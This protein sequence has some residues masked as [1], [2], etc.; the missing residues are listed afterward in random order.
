MER[1]TRSG[2]AAGDAGREAGARPSACWLCFC[3]AIMVACAAW[4][5]GR[6]PLIEPDEG[7][8]AEVAREMAVS[9]DFVL[10]HLDGLPY[11]DKPILFFAA[12]AAS[13][14]L[15][16]P[17][18]A[19]ARLPSFLFT[20][21]TLALTAWFG[22]CLLGR[23][24]GWVAA[25][26]TGAAPLT[27]VYARAVIFDAMLTFFV[28]LALVS[29]Y[30]AV[31]LQ[32]AAASEGGG[33]ERTRRAARWTALAWAAMGLGVLT[34]GPVALAVPLLVAVPYA[35]WR[36][37]W[38]ALWSPTAVALFAA[39]VL[40]W[41][42]AVTRRVPEFPRYVLFTET[43]GRLTSD[44][45]HRNEPWWY[46][47]FFITVGALPWSLVAATGVRRAGI[48]RPEGSAPDRRSVFILLWLLVPLIFFSLSHSKRPQY[49]LPLMPAVGLLVARLWS[50]R[51]GRLPGVRGAGAGLAALGLFLIVGHELVPSIRRVEPAV[52]DLIPRA[53]LVEG[54]LML[55]AGVA[56]WLVA[57]KR[58]VAL[59]ALSLPIAA[60]P[61][62]AHR[63]IVEISH[64]YSSAGIAAALRPVLTPQT[65]VIGVAVYPQSLPF[66]L[67]RIVIV[68]TPSGGKMKSNY[69][70]R[71]Y[72]R[73][74]EAPGTPLR[75]GDWWMERL[76]RCDPA[77]V[78]VLRSRDFKARRTLAQRLP[79]LVDNG[80]VAAYGPCAPAGTASGPPG[81]EPG[82]PGS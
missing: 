11:L 48:V 75:P 36:R 41:V 79:L 22:S 62:V 37:A 12:A 68:S 57:A 59:A 47:L 17:T 45:L 16:G 66:Y 60:L 61:I 7:R 14:K 3:A 72:D 29:F 69:I 39:V 46:F 1:Q 23:E 53:S 42:V 58:E 74:T 15:L 31:E 52:I 67:G 27:L 25:I 2:S 6:H 70:S 71:A 34:K 40:P 24:G 30:R 78:F 65:E 33:G 10:P 8:N 18:E 80:K 35:G 28:V 5:L 44:E 50:G 82:K 49:I 77:A 20:L 4:S 32:G 43:L 19:A 56:V 21:A 63:L 64:H 13:M 54:A 76:Q 55:A 38:R 73:L 9:G 51:R 26:A 81:G